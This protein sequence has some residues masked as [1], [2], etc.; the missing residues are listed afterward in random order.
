MFPRLLL[1]Y[2]NNFMG[3]ESLTEEQK[4]TD[5]TKRADAL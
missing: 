2:E 4:R 5:R 3:I 1:G